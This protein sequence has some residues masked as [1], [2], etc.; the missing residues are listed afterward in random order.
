MV[1]EKRELTPI[2]ELFIPVVL[3]KRELTP[4]AELALPVIVKFPAFLPTETLFVPKLWIKLSEPTF[5]IPVVAVVVDNVMF[6]AVVIFPEAPATWNKSPS[7][8]VNVAAGVVS[9]IPTL[10]FTNKEP[11]L[12]KLGSYPIPT[13]FSK[14]FIP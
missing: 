8:T 9:P 1:L 10:P 2:A 13:L 3:E 5:I 12:A 7:P 4:I 6:P 11:P 14:Y